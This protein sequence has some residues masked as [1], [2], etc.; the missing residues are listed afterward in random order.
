MTDFDKSS[1]AKRQ[2]EK[3]VDNLYVDHSRHWRDYRFVYPVLSR[4]AG[5]ISLGVDL[6]PGCECTFRC[7]YC[8][9]PKHNL[10]QPRP[11]LDLDMLHEELYLLFKG[12]KEGLLFNDAP[13]DATPANLRR[14]NDI[15]FSG[16]GEPTLSPH[17]AAAVRIAA[18]VKEDLGAPDVKLVL[19]TN[20]TCLDR[21]EVVK[22]LE[23]LMANN[24][25][26][27]AKLDAGTEPFYKTIDR[28]AV[29]FEKVLLNIQRTARKFPVVIQT[30]FSDFHGDGGPSPKEIEEYLLRLRDILD[31]GGTI[32][33]IQIH[34][35]RRIP[36]EK[37]AQPLSK[38]FLEAI[39]ER[40]RDTTGCPTFTYV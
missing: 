8:Q 6:N 4:R 13:F 24:G 25:E 28:S 32:D 35:V 5:G 11:T 22:G 37:G 36:A 10:P 39:A 9:I 33:H 7:V 30:L 17:F 40:V 29:P 27:W 20:S 31:V 1:D 14:I 26:I 3:R 19:I 18:E 16:S 2:A 34:T 38:D 21:S 23:T 12:T 15:A